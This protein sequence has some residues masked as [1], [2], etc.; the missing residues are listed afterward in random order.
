MFNKQSQRRE[1]KISFY[2][3]N[4]LDLESFFWVNELDDES[5]TFVKKKTEWIIFNGPKN[6]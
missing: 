6:K 3:H 2:I 5:E 4:C 1:Q